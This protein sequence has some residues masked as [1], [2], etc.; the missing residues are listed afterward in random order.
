MLNRVLQQRVSVIAA[1]SVDEMCISTNQ[2]LG[3][4]KNLYLE[5][6]NEAI[7]NPVVVHLKKTR[8]ERKNC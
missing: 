7:H 3:I 5:N 1:E 2:N 6:R 4:R 8:I